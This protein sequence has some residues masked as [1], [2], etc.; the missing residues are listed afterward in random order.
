MWLSLSYSGL[1]DHRVCG[2][3]PDFLSL[4]PTLFV[5]FVVRASVIL[6]Q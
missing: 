2:G 3:P 1:P 6:A 5:L 4:Y